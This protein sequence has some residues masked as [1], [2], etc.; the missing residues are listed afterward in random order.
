MSPEAAEGGTIGLVEDGDVIEIDIPARSISLKVDDKVLAERRAKWK[1]PK[2]K[3]TKG[4]AYRYSQ[5]V[6]S[7]S[8]GAVFKD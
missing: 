1:A 3:I 4:Y 5:M 2:P 6:T 7:A 8:T